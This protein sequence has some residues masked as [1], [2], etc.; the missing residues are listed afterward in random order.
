MC[1]NANQIIRTHEYYKQ[2]IV[3][4]QNKKIHDISIKDWIGNVF[5]DDIR[6]TP[7]FETKEAILNSDKYVE[8]YMKKEKIKEFQR[9]WYARS[10]PALNYGSLAN[11]MIAKIGLQKL[12]DLENKTSIKILPILGCGSSPFR[13]NFK[14]TNVK[15]MLKGYPSVQTF[16]A[17]SAFKYDFPLKEV[18]NGIDEIKDTKRTNPNIVEEENAIKIINKVEKDYVESIKLLAPMINHVEIPRR[19]KRKLHIDL[20]GYAR[21]SQG[22]KLPRAITF[23]AVL[24]SLGLPPEILGMSNLTQKDIDLVQSCYQNIWNDMQNSLQYLNKNNLDYFPLELKKKVL[25][26]IELFKYEVNQE[27]EELTS[28]IIKSKSKESILNAAQIRQFLG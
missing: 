5:P 27:H 26:V 14:P 17:Q 25:R 11:V 18:L 28:D 19:R 9:V 8:Q 23:C 21:Q 12:H 16:T 1:A 24:Y 6:V 22:V 2:M 4:S 13:G 3:N 15:T 10:D 7:L 20:F